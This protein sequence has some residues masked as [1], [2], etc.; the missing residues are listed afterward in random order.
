MN[1]VEH[2]DLCRKHHIQGYPTIR[3]FTRGSDLIAHGRHTD[4][5]SYHG[6][7]TV[8]AIV[9]FGKSMVDV[10]ADTIPVPQAKPTAENDLKPKPK[11]PNEKIDFKVANHAD[12][13]QTRG[14]SGC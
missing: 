1:C 9:E 12:V 8:N 10:P 4:H 3:I 5:A 14:S 11:P 13:V 2:E 7:R 6:D